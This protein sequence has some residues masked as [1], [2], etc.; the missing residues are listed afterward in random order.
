MANSVVSNVVHDGAANVL[1]VVTGILDTSDYA[2]TDITA[3]SSLNP[4][5]TLLRLDRVFFSIEDALS[6]MLWWEATSDVLIMPLAGRGKFDFDWFG[7][8]TN[9]K[10]AGF[11]GDIR[12]ST[13]GWVGVKHFSLALEFTK[14]F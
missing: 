3:I 10:A 4:V 13:A 2:V 11:T 8:W 12:L 14:Q 1:V 6:C 7:G 5:P 9:P